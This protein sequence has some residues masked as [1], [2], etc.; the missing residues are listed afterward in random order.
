MF[1]TIYKNW[2]NIKIDGTAW[3]NGVRMTRFKDGQMKTKAYASY[4]KE[5]NQGIKYFVND[6]PA[7]RHEYLSVADSYDSQKDVT[8]YQFND[9]EIL[10]KLG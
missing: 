9:T 3:G 1:S 8:W 2:Q 4:I 7:D 5:P 6:Y 10:N